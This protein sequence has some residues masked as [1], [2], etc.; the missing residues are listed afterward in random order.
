MTSGKQTLLQVVVCGALV[1][2][3][4]CQY[5]KPIAMAMSLLVGRQERVVR[6]E[7]RVEVEV[8]QADGEPVA[9]VML[10]ATGD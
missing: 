2:L 10:P 3:A 9:K 5:I 4:G 8:P 7:V 6:V 1:G